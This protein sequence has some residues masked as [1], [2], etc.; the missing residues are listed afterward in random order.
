V[1]F[2]YALWPMPANVQA[3]WST[4]QSGVSSQPFDSFNVGRHVGD[5]ALIVE[6]NRQLL[7]NRLQGYPAISWLNQ[8]HSILVTEASQADSNKSQD[9]SYTQ[10]PKLACCV[11]TA[12]CLPVFFWDEKGDQ[13]AV[14]HAGWRGLADG[15]LLKTLNTFS[16]PAKVYCARACYRL[17][18]I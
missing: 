5:A 13:V 11:M 7:R 2:Q 9:A 8:T 18:L 14:A 3:G 10:R 16:N 6:Q 17:Q 1:S 12:D 15:V 4:R